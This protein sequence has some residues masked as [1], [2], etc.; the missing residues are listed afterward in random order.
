MEEN[1]VIGIVKDFLE[2]YEKAEGTS[3]QILIPITVLLTLIY[4]FYKWVIVPL[5]RIAKT[6]FIYIQKKNFSKKTFHENLS[7]M[8]SEDVY[9]A[10]NHY[11]PTRYSSRDPAYNDEPI[12]EYMGEEARREPLLIN[13]FLKYEFD[14][15][16]GS[17][18]YLCLGD[19]GMGK[20]TFLINLYYETLRKRKH[21]C[22]FISLQDP[23][24]MEQIE[25][26][27]EPEKT[28]LLLDA[29]DE[30]ESAVTDFN[31]FMTS[32]E[33]C[34]KFFY[35]VI[36]T[37]RTNFFMTE[38]KEQLSIHKTSTSTTGK[39]FSARK[40]Y[41]APFTDEDIQNYLKQ[42]YR[43]KQYKKAWALVDAN[44]NLS[45]RPMLLRYIDDL[46]VEN[47]NF[48]YDYQL[49]E[50]L[51]VRWI[52]REKGA[53]SEQLGEGLYNECLILAKSIY[54]QWMKTGRVGIYPDEVNESS[55][56]PGLASIRFRGHA[57][58]NRRSD[59]MYKFAH[60]SF[61]EFLLAQS[62]LQDVYF[63]DDLLIRNFEQAEDFLN[64][65]ISSNEFKT[66]EALTGIANY[67]LKY[68]KPEDAETILQEVLRMTISEDLS[69]FAKIQLVKCLQ[70]QMKESSAER[71]LLQL[72]KR[73][74]NIELTENLV[75]LFSRFGNVLAHYSR[76]RRIKIGQE[77]IQDII[78][79]CK[80]N[81]ISGYDLLRC[82]ENFSYCALNY[83]S[84]IKAIEEMESL[85]SS[86]IDDQYADCLYTLASIRGQSFKDPEA[87]LFDK[88]LVSQYGKLRDNYELIVDNCRL[89]CAIVAVHF[90]N[91][92]SDFT[93]VQDEATD[94]LGRAYN[95]CYE[96]YNNG[97]E[98]LRDPYMATVAFNIITYF[99]LFSDY[100]QFRDKKIR[101][102]V[103]LLMQYRET[104]HLEDEMQTVFCKILKKSAKC[105]TEDF[106]I[107][108]KHQ[109]ERLA[110]SRAIQHKY[111][112]IDTLWDIF[113]LYSNNEKAEAQIYLKKA[114]DQACIDVDYMDTND[115]C[116]LLQVM[117]DF[118]DDACIKQH[119]F[120]TL[121][122]ITPVV[123]GKDIRRKRIYRSLRNY[124]LKNNKCEVLD[125]ARE[126]LR[127]DFTW[128]E[129]QQFYK[130][131][132]KFSSEANFIAQ[133]KSILCEFMEVGQNHQD[134]VEAFLNTSL[135][136]KDENNT[137]VDLTF[138]PEFIK[139][140]RET[141]RLV[142]Q[143]KDHEQFS[144]R[145]THSLFIRA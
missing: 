56:I 114:Y 44:K 60:K 58:L 20:T 45:V 14:Q 33:N 55:I 108:E 82:Y 49:Y 50:Y 83:A 28:I 109:F 74:R 53:V 103:Q 13:H 61:W 81:D 123:Y 29:L 23:K 104:Y 30:N 48:S 113:V 11:I 140:V 139:Q 46:L 90:D 69:L 71:C 39:I 31:S 57:L 134:A 41:I 89:A 47:K 137:F 117:L 97:F 121:S 10:I 52:E 118:Y 59:G 51:F 142:K 129:L 12:P 143:E 7:F 68:K 37:S 124:A 94:F 115:Y 88:R 35:R 116:I 80:Q 87:L 86:Q 128:S 95:I 136:Y 42:R 22:V 72:Y 16:Y 65:M 9:Y 70:R 19:C 101:E 66:P 141:L 78:D 131:C 64:E 76:N 67:Y 112:E 63:S 79:F 92:D 25:K 84:R 126:V 54:Y 102:C 21:K 15:K 125:F 130:V 4:C 100:E 43:F 91:P 17:K 120:E 98:P 6:V 110:F 40:Y 85:L 107:K 119:V 93:N 135:S 24:C 111:E 73:L 96:V 132:S 106:V 38:E 62:A 3:F 99:S 138:S 105:D 77:F 2:L 144:K 27:D 127:C 26:I 75:P 5:W 145:L 18:Y 34:T 122:Q 8:N 1:M 32:L 133:L 36:I